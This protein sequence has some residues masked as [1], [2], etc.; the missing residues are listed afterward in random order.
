MF[1][2][3]S[4]IGLLIALVVLAGIFLLVKYTENDDRTF[5]TKV[6]SYSPEQ[7]TALHIK[8]YQS[9]DD[10]EIRK[11]GEKW[12]LTGNGKEYNGGLESIANI[13]GL[14]NNLS[15]ESI[16]ATSS[17]KWEQYDVDENKGIRVQV[18]EGNKIVG[19]VFIG[20]FDF[21]QIPSPNPAQQPQTK[22]TSF[23]RPADEDQVYAVNGILR[24]NFQGG[25][26]PFRD[27]ALFLCDDHYDI[28]RVSLSGPNTQLELLQKD[29]ASWTINGIPADS[30]KTERYLRSL[31]SL[32]N[33]NFIDDVD[34]ENMTPQYTAI[35]EGSTFDPVQIKAFPA[36]DSFVGYYMTS[37]ENRGTVFNGMK[38]KSFEKVF[39]GPGTFLAE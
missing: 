8:D 9:G 38:S 13:I 27:R 6:L 26:K 22:M 20:K 1:R 5:R 19:D 34:V 29:P 18:Y 37:S 15:T 25:A 21:K 14:L 32:R 16:V 11:E 7:V 3:T 24:S 31:S 23:V 2:K 4:I 12:I 35:I 36:S 33:H 30:A 28:S 39:A 17:D 10:T